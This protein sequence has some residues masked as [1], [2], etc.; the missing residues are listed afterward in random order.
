MRKEDV[1][2]RLEPGGVHASCLNPRWLGSGQQK[3]LCVACSL[4]RYVEAAVGTPTPN[5]ECGSS[6]VTIASG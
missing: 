6:S 3:P 2:S 4:R 1:Q 5:A